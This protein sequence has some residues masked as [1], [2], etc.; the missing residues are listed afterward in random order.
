MSDADSS[1][2]DVDLV[3]VKV[4]VFDIGQHYHTEGL[5]DLPHIYVIFLHT[6]ILQ[7]LYNV[8]QINFHIHKINN[9]HAYVHTNFLCNYNGTL[10]I[11]MLHKSIYT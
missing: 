9:I 3:H 8:Y 2:M 7:H 5:V 4:E 1:S 11:T 6:C 10:M